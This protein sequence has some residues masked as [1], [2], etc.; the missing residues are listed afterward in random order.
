ML[1][2]RTTYSTGTD[3]SYNANTPANTGRSSGHQT[4]IVHGTFANQISLCA[5]PRLVMYVAPSQT[6]TKLPIPPPAGTETCVAELAEG[7]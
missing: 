6:T 7:A 1:L 5:N 3:I 2:S 4:L